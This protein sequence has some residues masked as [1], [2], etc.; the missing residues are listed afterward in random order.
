MIMQS[1]KSR[2]LL[3][4]TLW[5]IVLVWFSSCAT[6]QDKSGKK[7]HLLPEIDMLEM[8]E[9]SDVALRLVQQTRM[10]MDAL[11]TRLAELERIVV[12]LSNTLQSLPLARMEELQNRVTLVNEELQL[13]KKQVAEGAKVPTFH[14]KRQAK[15]S[16]TDA[17]AN[18]RS[19]INAFDNKNFGVAAGFF[20]KAIQ[21]DP[22]GKYADDAWYWIGESWF[23]MGDFARAMTAYQKVFHYINTDKG[24]DAQFRIAQCFLKLGDRDRAAHEFRKVEVLYPESEYVQKVKL[25]LKK[26][27]VH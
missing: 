10:D 22:Q 27:G 2:F 25:E 19:G 1:I 26:I 5:L 20:E 16:L 6:A 9:N 8:K 23:R 11:S 17:P 4:T 24:D 12:D 13:L 3:L 21:E 14:P 15:P 7:S 18:Y